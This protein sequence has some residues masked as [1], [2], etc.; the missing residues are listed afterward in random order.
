MKNIVFMMDIDLEGKGDHD[1]RYHSKRSFPYQNSIASWKH[2]WKKHNCELFVLNDLLFPNT[3]MPI[4][5][6]RHYIFDLMESNGVKYDQIL[7]VDADTIVH[8]DCPN[9]FEMTNNKFTVVT[10]LYNGNSTGLSS[11]V[12]N[13]TVTTS[14]FTWYQD[15]TG[16]SGRLGG[17]IAIG[18]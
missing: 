1:N 12:L 7:S 15:D 10:G 5:F 11:L 6:Q 8:P 13:S 16:Q 2:W 18:N 14:G 17:Y 9:F 4:C 3:E